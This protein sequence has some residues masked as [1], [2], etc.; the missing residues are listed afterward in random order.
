MYIT[1]DF[2]KTLLTF[3]NANLWHHHLGHPGHSVL[4]NVGLPDP[5]HSCLTCE[6]NKSH[7]LPFLH[8]FEPVRYPLDTI[9]IDLVGP[10]TPESVSGFFFLF[11][12]V[13]QATSY[14]MIRFLARKSNIF[15]KAVVAKKTTWR[16]TMIEK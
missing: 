16:I 15:N 10:I 8:H 4:K 2:P 13:D 14:K 3:A 11:T 12:I 5:N 1:Y 6:S 9:H 7:E